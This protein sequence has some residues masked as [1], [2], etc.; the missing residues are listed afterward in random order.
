[1][2]FR[3]LHSRAV[4]LANSGSVAVALVDAAR[5]AAF[6]PKEKGI[7]ETRAALAELMEKKIAAVQQLLA[8]VAST[9][10]AQLNAA[11]RAMHADTKA[12]YRHVNEFAESD[13]PARIAISLAHARAAT[14]F[15]RLGLAVPENARLFEEEAHLADGLVQILSNPPTDGE[16]LKRAWAKA[17]AQDPAL[18]AYP[19]EPILRYLRRRLFEKDQ[20]KTMAHPKLAISVQPARRSLE[21]FTGWLFSRE[22]IVTKLVAT[23][24]VV[25]V[26]WSSIVVGGT[27]RQRNIRETAFARLEAAVAA[28]D[29]RQTIDAAAAFFHTAP[30]PKG[31]RAREAHA[32]NHYGE[33]MTRWFIRKQGPPDAKDLAMLGQ[34]RALTGKQPP[35]VTR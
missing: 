29:D 33:A 32:L 24:A 16:G 8:Q 31:D 26:V 13:Q 3:S 17:V 5:A 7:E 18:A 23:A 20:P 27:L 25:A 35:E 1:V 2:L 6:N 19:V 10:N 28:Q 34:Y 21:P 4:Q 14:L 15:R 22:A 9:P 30:P 11:G 12:N